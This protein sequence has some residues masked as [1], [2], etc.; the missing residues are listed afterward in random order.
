MPWEPFHL[1]REQIYEAV[2]SAP[3]H[4]A[5]KRLGISGGALGK[6]C[7]NCHAPLTAQRDTLLRKLVFCELRVQG[8]DRFVHDGVA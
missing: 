4:D 5:A 6:T 3:M 2:W 7:K 1:S 8:S